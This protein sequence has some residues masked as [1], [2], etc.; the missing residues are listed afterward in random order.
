[1]KGSFSVLLAGLTT[2]IPLV[3]SGPVHVGA[4]PSSWTPTGSDLA[5]SLTRRKEAK[6]TCATQ[7]DQLCITKFEYRDKKD[8][9][10]CKPCDLGQK[11]NMKGDGCVKDKN[12]DKKHGKCSIGDILDPEE[13]GQDKNTDN[14]VCAPDDSVLC[15]KGFVPTSRDEQNRGNRDFKPDC[16]PKQKKN[17]GE[18]E[19]LYVMRV[20]NKPMFMCK[21]KR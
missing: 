18:K 16:V 11:L 13:L 9:C 4:L 15:Q 21:Q 1:M 19:F 5:P 12:W 8:A 14:P 17:C 6:D 2:F 10:S 7:C 3:V 20:E